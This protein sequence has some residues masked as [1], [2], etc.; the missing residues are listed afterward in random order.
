LGIIGFGLGVASVLSFQPPGVLGLLAG[1][2]AAGAGTLAY[3]VRAPQGR[4]TSEPQTATRP[5]SVDGPPVATPGPVPVLAGAALIDP[6]TGLYSEQYLLVA[7]D[8]RIAAARRR[9]RPISVAMLDIVADVGNRAD[10]GGGADVGNRAAALTP[11]DATAVADAIHATL[12]EADTAS[13]FANGRYVLMLE[14]TGE[15]GAIWTVERLRSALAAEVPGTTIRAG[16]ACYPAHAFDFDEILHQAE[17]ALGLAR[18]WRQDRI[19]VATG[20]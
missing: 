14:D 7:L 4:D 9:L 11:A 1:L 18:E 6:V 20:N 13:R 10:V 3:R 16:I 15:T 5:S 8:A 2:C 19:E 17:V 12:R